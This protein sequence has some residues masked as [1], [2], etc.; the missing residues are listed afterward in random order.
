[1]QYTVKF[2]PIRITGRTK[3]EVY[4]RAIRG[5][6]PI[7]GISKGVSYSGYSNIMDRHNDV[8]R[9]VNFKKHRRITTHDKNKKTTVVSAAYWEAFIYNIPVSF[10]VTFKLNL[11]QYTRHFV[12]EP[13]KY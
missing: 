8:I 6:C 11:K 7:S 5:Y 9:V 4:E 3:A 12:F 2:K 1:M 10:L 13:V